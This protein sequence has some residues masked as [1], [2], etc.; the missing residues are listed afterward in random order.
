MSMVSL[1]SRLDRVEAGLT[2]QLAAP[3]GV[4]DVDCVMDGRPN[5]ELSRLIGDIM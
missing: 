2:V 4:V 3:R 1:L 5:T